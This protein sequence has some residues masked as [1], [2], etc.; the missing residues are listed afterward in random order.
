MFPSTRSSCYSPM[1][2]GCT[3]SRAGITHWHRTAGAK[4]RP[5]AFVSVERL[6]EDFFGEAER[7]LNEQGVAFE[8]VDEKED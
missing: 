8:I 4:G 6:L 3:T 7:V 1:T 2:D 5:Y